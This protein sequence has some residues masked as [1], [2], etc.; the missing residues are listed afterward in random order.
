MKYNNANVF[1]DDEMWPSAN[2]LKYCL[3][4]SWYVA[5]QW[6]SAEMAN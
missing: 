2:L 3:A 5:T 4:A 6:K 1:N